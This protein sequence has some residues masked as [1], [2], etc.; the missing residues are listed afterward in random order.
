MLDKE[1]DPLRFFVYP[2]YCFVINMRKTY[3]RNK[4]CS[5]YFTSYLMSNRIKGLVLFCT[6]KSLQQSLILLFFS[7]IVKKLTFTTN[8][9]PFFIF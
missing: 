7:V 4:Y 9:E 5:F 3:G 2:D 6:F 8:S 1:A